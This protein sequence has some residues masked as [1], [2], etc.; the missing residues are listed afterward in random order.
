M[1][2]YDKIVQDYNNDDVEDI[3]EILGGNT[4]ALFKI[5]D[6]K[7]K[8]DDLDYETP[9][10]NELFLYISRNY[11][12]KFKNIATDTLVDVEI[13]SDGELV[14]IASDYED[15]AS[16]FCEG[17]YSLSRDSIE[18]ILDDERD[19]FEFLF[20]DTTDDLYR[21]VVEDLTEENLQ[22]LTKRLSNESPLIEPTTEL[23][24]KLASGQNNEGLVK[25]NEENLDEILEDEK[26]T[27]S[28]LNQNQDIKSD[29]Y[30]IHNSAY[31]DAYFSEVRKNVLSGLEEL[32]EGIPKR[33]PG[34]NNKK[35]YVEIKL[36]ENIFFE[37][38]ENFLEQNRQ[39]SEE[40]IDRYGYFNSIFGEVSDCLSTFAPDY[41][42]WTKTKENINLIFPDYF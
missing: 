31:N 1:D 22:L 40:T 27:L 7:G 11:P 2:K 18:H 13:N 19:N 21:D 42:D 26:S 32:F 15:L 23:L 10:Q 38:L 4:Q 28:V 37:T 9:L 8:L 24:T 39:W 29:L 3:L 34:F 33:K 12:T 36:K 5:L 16:F 30:R 17:R 6:K 20:D 14:Y 41:A 25:I 35:F